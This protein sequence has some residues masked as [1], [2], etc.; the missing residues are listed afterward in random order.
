MATWSKAVGLKSAEAL[1]DLKPSQLA[2]GHGKVLTNPVP[3]M[4]QAIDDTKRSLK[5]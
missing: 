3:A 4:Q 1:R 5:A 2:V